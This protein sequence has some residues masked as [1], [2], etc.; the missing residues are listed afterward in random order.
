MKERLEGL[1]PEVSNEKSSTRPKQ[2]SKKKISL[3]E[4]G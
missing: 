3:I 1:I 4:L 2:N